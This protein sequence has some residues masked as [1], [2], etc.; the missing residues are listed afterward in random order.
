MGYD[1]LLALREELLRQQLTGFLVPH[2][3]EYQNEYLPPCA[4][5]LAWLTGF[6]GSAG[7]A[8]VLRDD[9]AMFVDGRY[10]LQV[11]E[12]VD[13]TSFSLNNSG[14]IPPHEWLSHHATST[15]RIGYDP[16]LHTPQELER[17]QKASN[18]AGAQLVPCSPN[19]IDQIW[20]DRPDQPLGLIKPHL[21]EFSGQ[22]S[23]SKREA[24]AGKLLDD[25]ID[26]AI[27]AAPDSIAWLLNIRGSDV[28]HTPLP[29]CQAILYATGRVALFV[30][31]QKISQGLQAHAGPDISFALPGEFEAALQ[32]LGA[33]GNRVLCD[34]AKTNTWIF[35]ILTQSGAHLLHHDDP[36][37]LP[38]ACK[39]SVEIAGAYAAHQRDG[40][41]MCQFLAWLAR[42]ASK[43]QVTELEAVDYLDACRRK[44]TMWEDC[45]FPTISGAGSNGAIVHYHSTPETNR[46]L[47]PGTL[48]LV[49]SGGQYL[50]GTTDIT[51]TLAIGCPSDEHR[52]RYTRVLQGH[53]AL[54]TARFPEGTTGSQLDALAR[55]PLWAIGLDYDHGTGHGVGSF[56]GVH[57]GPQ[58]IA[59][60]ANTV[61][62]KPG[63]IVSNEPGY[64][65]AGA[66]GIRLENLVTVVNDESF[67]SSTRAFLAFDTLTIVPFERALIAT[68]VLSLEERQWVDT[69]HARVWADLQ[70]IVDTDTRAWLEQATQPL[71]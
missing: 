60:S 2:T 50:D 9:A 28:S 54:A 33:H 22:T 49:D 64:Y 29:L 17:F 39:N 69:Y 35:T 32:Q 18:R 55:A 34:P 68:D 43:G 19:P 16:W 46:C 8:I 20:H 21:L 40:V 38:K 5:R 42:E 25:Q 37:V 52:D 71:I 65:K 3:D 13:E 70:S 41:A 61:A 66:Y 4:E 27:I 1:R 48:Y 31:P 23:Q 67:T 47:E 59:K 53:I 36:C 24:L 14:E 62:L 15:D 30:D 6:T 51:R 11:A 45:S 63:M 44:Q 57:E 26:A 58:R 7:T 12:Q 56:L 10:T